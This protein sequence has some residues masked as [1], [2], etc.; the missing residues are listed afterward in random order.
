MRSNLSSKIFESALEKSKHLN[1][2]TA[3]AFAKLVADMSMSLS[4]LP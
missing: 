3:Q 4:V 2:K 1:L